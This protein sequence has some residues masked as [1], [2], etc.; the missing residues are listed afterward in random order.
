[1]WKPLWI[2]TADSKDNAKCKLKM[3]NECVGI[4]DYS[5]HLRRQIP[6]L[7]ISLPFGGIATPV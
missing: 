7:S 2:T 5:N 6:Q 3:E 1:M 4:A